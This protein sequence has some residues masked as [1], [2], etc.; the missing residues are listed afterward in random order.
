MTNNTS[1]KLYLNKKMVRWWNTVIH[2]NLAVARSKYLA[3]VGRLT[4]EFVISIKEMVFKACPEI[5]TEVDNWKESSLRTSIV[6]DKISADIFST[7][8]QNQA[9]AIHPLVGQKIKAA[10][11]P[12]Y[13]ECGQAK[14]TAFPTL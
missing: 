12:I 9:S 6:I 10:W 1:A 5:A 2:K 4:E 13:T 14:G 8:I 3:G 7:T 11:M